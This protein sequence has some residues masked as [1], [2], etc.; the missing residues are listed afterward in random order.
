MVKDRMLA[1]APLTCE[2]CGG[3]M[4]AGAQVLCADGYPRT[5]GEYVLSEED[6]GL[7]EENWPVAHVRCV[8]AL[9]FMP[10]Q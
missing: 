9:D 4:Q 8:D 1:P 6:D 2:E 3:V 10:D 7:H 5:Y